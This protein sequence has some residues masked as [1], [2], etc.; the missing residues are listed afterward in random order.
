MAGWDIT[1]NNKFYLVM[2]ILLLNLFSDIWGPHHV[3]TSYIASISIAWQIG[4]DLISCQQEIRNTPRET[5][6]IRSAQLETQPAAFR[7]SAIQ[8][9]DLVIINRIFIQPD[10][11]NFIWYNY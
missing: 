11:Y 1:K 5:H 10:T 9:P 7:L 8:N 4:I 2:L 6:D 3:S